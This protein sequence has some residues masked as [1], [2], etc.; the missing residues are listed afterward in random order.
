MNGRT[1][2]VAHGGSSRLRRITDHLYVYEDYCAV[3]ILL[4]GEHALLVECGSG[5][6]V[7]SLHELGVKHVDWVVHTHHHRDGCW[8]DH[9]LVDMGA[10]IAV[11]EREAHLFEQVEDY[12]EHLA[13]FDNYYLG[14]DSYSLPSNVPVSIRLTDYATFTWRQYAMRVIPAPGHTQGSI[15][16]MAEVDGLTVAFTGDLIASAGRLWHVYAMQWQY[17][18]GWGDAAGIQAS[19]LSLTEVLDAQP[20]LLL[21]SHGQVMSNPETAVRK[22]L[23]GLRELYRYLEGSS[24]LAHP[25]WLITDRQLSRLSNHLWMNRASLANSYTLIAD[26]GDG[27][28]LDYGYPSLSHFSG[29][30][31]F[32]RHSLRELFARG[33]LRKPDLFIPSH[34]HDDHIVGAPLLQREFGVRIWA[35]EVFTDILR[36]PAAYSLP[37]LLPEPLEVERDL[38]DGEKFEWNGFDFEIRHTPG[39]T[40]Y[41]SSLF[42][43]VD[44]IRA[45]LAGDNLHIGTFGPLLGGPVYRN[46][47]EVGDFAKSI[48]QLCEWSPDLLLTGHSGAIQVEP[49][50]LDSSLRRARELDDIL[51]SIVY[52]PEEAGFALDPSWARI[53]PYQIELSPGV[54]AE[55][56]VQIHNHG[57]KSV[58]AS[59]VLVAPA[60]WL[61]NPE[62]REITIDAR[63]EQQCTFTLCAPCESTAMSTDVICAVIELDDGTH[64]R[65]YG[66]VAEALVRLSDGN[67]R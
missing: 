43:E 60:G 45:V 40:H 2:D 37:C 9:R 52:V 19:A 21:P 32:A 42:I 31:R 12:W 35:H 4:D 16:L 18:G 24:F 15:A 26:D 11:P 50:W 22:L 59:I 44:G 64:K 61:V 54:L 56:S 29:R 41:A 27:L 14:S 36:R 58:T 8:G 49:A 63:Q 25:S 6:V 62:R 65:R 1:G 5:D 46:R 53:S 30:F 28:F 13:V 57:R 51:N 39:H 67:S 20:D 48:L 66:P 38:R 3:Y 34:Y 47:Y 10:R 7:D 55:L 33:G 23:G 17:G